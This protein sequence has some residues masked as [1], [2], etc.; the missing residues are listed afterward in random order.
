MR[1]PPRPPGQGKP[2]V[3]QPALRARR[4]GPIRSG[5]V[6]PG[7]A[8][9]RAGYGPHPAHHDHTVRF[10]PPPTGRGGTARFRPSRG[11]SPTV[12]GWSRPRWAGPVP[13]RLRRA[14]PLARSRP[15]AAEFGP[16]ILPARPIPSGT[17][18][19]R[20]FPA[21]WEPSRRTRRTRQFPSDPGCPQPSSVRPVL[22]VPGRTDHS[23]SVPSGSSRVRA[24]PDS[25]RPRPVGRGRHRPAPAAPFRHGV[26]G[27]TRSD[28]AAPVHTWPP[29]PEPAAGTRPRT[30]GTRPGP[31]REPAEHR[32]RARLDAAGSRHGPDRE[33]A[34]TWLRAS[35]APAENRPEPELTASRVP[36][37]SP[38]GPDRKPPE[39]RPDPAGSPPGPGRKPARTRPEARPDPGVR[40]R[41]VVRP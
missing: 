16:A 41:P 11:R 21:E 15:R 36:T 34:R 30:A 28:A 31:D 22:A 26:P 40:Q 12:V 9:A 35:R 18:R 8:T 1:E 39:A 7:Q 2:S 23:W 38:P 5:Q 19:S 27:R 37:E 29:R 3:S 32:P 10:R 17:G 33:P 4:F 20:P 13:T 14:W 24:A 25:R 6:R